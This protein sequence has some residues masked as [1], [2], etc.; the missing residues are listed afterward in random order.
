[1]RYPRV[2]PRPNNVCVCVYIVDLANGKSN[3]FEVMNKPNQSVTVQRK[4]NPCLPLICHV[5]NVTNFTL[6]YN[7]LQG[8]LKSRFYARDKSSH[9]SYNIWVYGASGFY[10]TP[11]YSYFCHHISHSRIPFLDQFLWNYFGKR[12]LHWFEIEDFHDFR[13]RVD[14]IDFFLVIM[15]SNSGRF[16]CL[17]RTRDYILFFKSAFPS[18]NLNQVHTHAPQKIHDSIAPDCNSSMLCLSW[19]ILKADT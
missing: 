18:G 13:R 8:F 11:F 17:R 9:I 5:G 19:S 14:K 1:M 7:L 3:C 10:F 2:I 15:F 12:K 6:R 4:M 16:S